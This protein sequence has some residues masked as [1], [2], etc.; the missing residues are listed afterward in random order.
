MKEKRSL[1]ASIP[2]GIIFGLIIGILIYFGLG[3]LGY[4][5]YQAK[6]KIITTSLD[7]VD[8]DNVATQNYTATINSNKIKQ[9]TLENLGID[10]SLGVFNTKLSIEPIEGSSVV[11]IVVTDTNKLRAE[12]M[13]DEY[14]DLAIRAIKNIYQTDAQVMEYAYQNA[15]KVNNF[16][17][18]GLIG[19]GIAFV[20]FTLISMIATNSYNNKL[21]KAY[22]ENQGQFRNRPVENEEIENKNTRAERRVSFKKVE[23]EEPTSLDEDL[24]EDFLEDEAIEEDFTEE[25]LAYEDD[26]DATRVINRNEVMENLG[27]EEDASY[28]ILGKIPP[29]SKGDLDV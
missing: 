2:K 13:A 25:N 1:L 16:L 9:T 15:G 12:D 6:S 20:V 11:D 4:D 23:E 29:Y 27:Q 17:S 8:A 26:M 19:G 3:F 5:E 10:M 24:E 22:Y 14:A 7:T 21:I 18:Y 28:K